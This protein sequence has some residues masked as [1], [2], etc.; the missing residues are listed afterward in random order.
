MVREAWIVAT[1]GAGVERG[2]DCRGGERVAAT[3]MP[4]GRGEGGSERD[5]DKGER[6][7]SGTGRD[8]GRRDGCSSRLRSVPGSGVDVAAAAN[9]AF[10]FARP[11]SLAFFLLLLFPTLYLF[12]YTFTTTLLEAFPTC[13]E[14]FLFAGSMLGDA[15]T[16]TNE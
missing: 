12:G 16:S 9:A 6:D 13:S 7:G 15:T 11:I 10:I 4:W 8:G 3:T 5:G 1:V 2:T 14:C